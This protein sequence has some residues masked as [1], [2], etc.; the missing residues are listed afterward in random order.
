MGARTKWL[1]YL[2]WALA[3]VLG[4][5][6]IV[7]FV[8]M[9]WMSFVEMG[10]PEPGVLVWDTMLSFAF[11]LQ[12]SGM[13]RRRFRASLSRVMPKRY[14]GAFYAI[15]SGVVLALVAVL[16]QRSRTHLFA[17]E[18][19][20]LWVARALTVVAV[21]VFVRSAYVLG[22]LFDPLGIRPIKAHLHDASEAPS[23]FLV[24]GPY[25]WVRHP[26]Y[27]CV[28]L[29]F[30]CT[31]DVTADRLLFNG[32]WTGWICVATVLEERDLVAE[33]GDAYR[34]YQRKVPMLIPWRGRVAT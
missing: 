7:L 8:A 3:A 33:F 6:S 24:Q 13:V 14:E 18:G 22:S 30:W 28:V 9:S 26:L 2:M 4:T 17:L 32:L 29:L 12:H 19:P 10:W 31:A 27:S 25:R 21:A 23:A 1:D 20:P 34:D 11:F 16:W 5:G 15:A